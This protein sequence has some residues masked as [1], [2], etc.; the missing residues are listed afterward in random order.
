M[1]IS[2]SIVVE[3]WEAFADLVPANKRED[4][5]CRLIEI[6]N[7]QHPEPDWFDLM[8]GADQYL[9][10]ALDLVFEEDDDGRDDQDDEYED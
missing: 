1:E 7:E 6:F 9:D 5:A 8:R 2:S 3:I 4:L 10:S